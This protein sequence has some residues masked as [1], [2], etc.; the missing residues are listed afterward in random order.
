MERN[1]YKIILRA[2]LKRYLLLYRECSKRLS[3]TLLRQALIFFL[4]F[5]LVINV[6]SQESEET[7]KEEKEKNPEEKNYYVEPRSYGTKR[8]P[9]PPEYVR[10]LSKTGI[11]AVKD[12]DWLDVGLDYRTRY[13]YRENDFRRNV[14]DIDRP[15]LL[16]ARGFLGLKE[17]LDPFRFTLEVED[18]QRKYS[19]FEPDDRDYNRAEPIQAFAELFYKDG[20]GTN[21][22]LSVRAGRMAFEFLDRRLIGLNEWRNT[23]NTFQGLRVS[24]GKD[25]NNW[26]VDMLA[27][28]PLQRHIDRLDEPVRNQLFYAVIGNIRFLSDIVTIQP[29]YMGLKQSKLNEPVFSKTKLAFEDRKRRGREI[30]TIGT[31]FYGLIGKTG[32]DYDISATYQFGM[33]DTEKQISQASYS[34]VLES[35]Y[36]FSHSWKPRLGVFYGYVSGDRD[37]NDK[38]NNRFERLF[39]FARPWSSSDYF[40]MENLSSPKVVLEFS[41]LPNL[42]IDTAIVRF[43]LASE[44][45]RWNS[46]NLKDETGKSG[47]YLGDEFNIRFRFP[48]LSRVKANIGYAFFKPGSFTVDT[49]GRERDS[50]FT[51]LELSFNLFE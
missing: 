29:Y 28:Q 46:A 33:D 43:Y 17:K 41:P 4:V 9:F 10:N 11:G 35:G 47:K 50:H 48:L 34:Y 42:K 5:I 39:G 49:S 15:L 1:S 19:M 22:P 30:H 26:S 18:A 31:R 32:F 25:S 3:A 2:C 7:A 40:Q 45:D 37:P 38:V 51:Y 44:T 12:V 6:S 27:L 24:L 8:I 14:P 23:T 13:E 20:L 36:T 21:R 16:R